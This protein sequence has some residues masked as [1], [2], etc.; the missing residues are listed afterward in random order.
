[1][2]TSRTVENEPTVGSAPA[3]DFYQMFIDGEWIGRAAR[4]AGDRR[5]GHRGA[6]RPRGERRRR[7]GPSRRRSRSPRLRRRALAAHDRTR[8]RRRLRAAAAEVRE[9]ADELA[10]LET[11]Q[12]GKLLGD[13]LYDMG[14]VAYCLEYAASL[15]TTH[16]GQQTT[17]V[18]PPSFGVVV[19]EPI[20]V[21]VGITPWNFPLL[22]GAWKFASALAAGNVVIIKPASV[23]P[24]TT[25]EMAR[26]FD[27]VGLPRGVFQVVVGPGSKVGDYFC[28]SPLV[29]MVTLTGSLEVGVHIMRQAAGTV[30]KVGLELGGKSPNIVFADADFEA[31]LQGTLFGAFANSGQVCC[32]GSRLILERPIYDEFTAE[33]E[34]RAQAIKVGP[35]LDPSSEMGPLVSRDQLETTERYVKLGVEEGARLLCGGRRIV[36]K[37]YYYE[38]T[39]FV[40]VDNSMR[41]AQEEIFGPVLVVIPFDSEDEAIAI[42]NDTIYGLAGGVWTK[43]GAK[44]LRVAQAVRAGTMYVNTYNWS[45]VELPW[46]GYKQSGVGRELGSFG[47]DEFTEA[48]S[49]IFDTS[50]QPLGL[51][52]SATVRPARA[53]RLRRRARAGRREGEGQPREGIDDR[54]SDLGDVGTTAA[55]PRHRGAA[56][57]QSGRESGRAGRGCRRSSVKARTVPLSRHTALG[58]PFVRSEAGAGPG[59]AGK[60]EPCRRPATGAARRAAARG[61]GIRAG[62]P[63]GLTGE[64]ATRGSAPPR[65][66]LRS[67]SGFRRAAL[68]CSGPTRTRSC[69]A[70][71]RSV[72]CA[73]RRAK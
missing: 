52:T 73:R 6:R 19:R 35:G 64:R 31:A 55:A 57:T 12:M 41:I 50:S 45:P 38:P 62:S 47:I 16:Q 39:I 5:P 37:G 34:Q 56:R 7:R 36:R 53:R 42:A 21:V 67:A 70:W 4:L 30:K 28:T 8:A 14:D 22:L 11:L 44:A 23:S 13:S 72:R 20:G 54:L 25:I 60:P 61:A 69:S 9:R 71:P 15:A 46:G 26:I 18:S 2:S 33:L 29:D 59:W 43:D 58:L 66:V 63:A 51:Y 1:M 40:D 3:V 65:C 32:A 68:P 17:T 24:L 27:D 48:K 49:V 10:R